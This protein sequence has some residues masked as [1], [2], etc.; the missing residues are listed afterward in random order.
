MRSLE[1]VYLNSSNKGNSD[2]LTFQFFEYALVITSSR[3]LPVL[4]NKTKTFFHKWNV[5]HYQ[6]ESSLFLIVFPCVY[7]KDLTESQ[8]K[9]FDPNLVQV[10]LLDLGE[11]SI[12]IIVIY[13]YAAP[14]VCMWKRILNFLIV[15]MTFTRIFIT[16]QLIETRELMIFC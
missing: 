6:T 16:I 2:V 14:V 1:S 4:G 12:C 7:L 15:Q 13:Y 3:K 9:Y 10:F 5:M 11:L 8:L